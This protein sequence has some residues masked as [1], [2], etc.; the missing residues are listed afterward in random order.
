MLPEML[1][2]GVGFLDTDIS[3]TVNSLLVKLE[4]EM[5]VIMG[6]IMMAVYLPMFDYMTHLK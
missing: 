2:K 4:P 1:N 6:T 3:H 5:T